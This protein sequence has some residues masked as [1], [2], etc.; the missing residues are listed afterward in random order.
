MIDE[1]ELKG[2]EGGGVNLGRHQA[3][4]TICSSPYREEIEQEWISWRATYSLA[5]QFGFTR[6]AIYRHA[7]ALDLFKKRQRNIRM[8]LERMIEAMEYAQITCPAVISAVKEYVKMTGAEQGKENQQG[9]DL[10][11]LFERMSKE[12]RE[13]FVCDGSLPNW[14]SS[15]KGATPSDSQAGEKESEVTD[16]KRLQ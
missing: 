3:Q 9:A 12:E 5:E 7:H 8:A 16:T 2:N 10:K 6:Y 11:N 15:P 13:A 14:F 4:C 1:K